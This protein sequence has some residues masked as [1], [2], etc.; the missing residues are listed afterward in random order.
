MS[1]FKFF[2]NCISDGT[3]CPAAWFG[4]DGHCY[5]L[6]ITHKSFEDARSSCFK[7]DSYLFSP[8]NSS[9]VWSLLDSL[10]NISVLNHVDRLITGILVVYFNTTHV[11]SD[12]VTLGELLFII[13]IQ[14]LLVLQIVTNQKCTFCLKFAVA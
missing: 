14:V 5:K 2:Y 13:L 12:G 4:K 11:T 10:Q 6:F 1:C 7:Q 3:V 9:K 8:T